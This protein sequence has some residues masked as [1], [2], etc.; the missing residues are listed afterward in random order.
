[1]P[2]NVAVPLLAFGGLSIARC[3]G[4]ELGVLVRSYAD[5]IITLLLS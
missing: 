1:M 3:Y 2:E 4:V 5:I